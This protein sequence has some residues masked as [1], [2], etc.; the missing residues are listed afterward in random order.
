MKE[1]TPPTLLDPGPRGP[2]RRREPT[3]QSRVLELQRS[4]GN[5]ATSELVVQRSKAT[6]EGETVEISF[7]H[8]KRDKAEA[9]KLIKEIKDKY[10]I[11]LDSQATIDGI[12]AQ[13]TSVPKKIT[14]SLEKRKWR[15]K[16]LRALSRALAFYAPILGA[17]RAKSSRASADQ[18]VTSVGKVKNA[19]DTNK[20]IGKLDTTTLG[21][22]FRAK[23]NMGMFKA[24]EGYTS[25]F[26][27]EGDQLTGTFV[28]EIAHG[29]LE[30]AL[31]DYIKATDGYWT[32]RSTKSGK[33]GAEAPITDYGA[34]NAAEDM[35]ESAMMFFI[36]PKRLK[37]GD[38]K[39]AGTPGNP[40][41]KRCAFMEQLGKDWVPAPPKTAIVE[42]EKPGTAPG[43][44][45]MNPF[46][47][48][49]S[50]GPVGEEFSVDELYAGP[51][52]AVPEGS[53]PGEPTAVA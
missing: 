18:E 32:D 37:D 20:P 33:K 28:H 27:D 15:L 14:D 42:D 34:K 39:P 9:A 19:I 43:D 3:P 13:Y 31:P 24:S 6:V 38:G 7:W 8:K 23:K 17:Q 35:C 2:A 29:L 12:K 26:S 52:A 50:A 10:G 53:P 40:C 22:Y 46:E 5:R 11:A 41:P 16:E 51:D 44:G 30:Y 49:A 36:K 47:D 4:A 1:R 21:E 25:D 45:L 48:D